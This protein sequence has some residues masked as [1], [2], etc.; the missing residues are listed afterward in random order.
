MQ[1]DLENRN[2]D[3]K[4]LTRDLINQKYEL[5]E[6]QNIKILFFANMSHELKLH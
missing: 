3:L 6:T 1:I 2:K 4:K 5:I